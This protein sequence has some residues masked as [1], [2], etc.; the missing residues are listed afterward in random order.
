MRRAA[1]PKSQR[2]YVHVQNSPAQRLA[3]KIGESAPMPEYVEPLLATE[4]SPPRG[5]RWVHEIKYDGYRFQ[6]YFRNG[7]PQFLTRRG[8]DWTHKVRR[9]VG[10]TVHIDCHN[11]IID[12]EMVIPTENGGTDFGSL[13]TELSLGNS[14]RIAFYAFDNLYLDGY[15]LRRCGLID[16]KEVLRLLLEKAEYPIVFSDHTDDPDGP[17][18]YREACKAELEGI[19]SKR[20]DAPYSSGRSSAWIKKPCRK[21]DTFFVAGWAEKG[22]SF[23][24]LYL[25]KRS[26]RK[27]VYAGKLERG[28]SAKEEREIVA[29]LKPLVAVKQPMTATR[30]RFPKAKWVK[31]ELMVEAEFRGRTAEGLLRHPSFKGVREDLT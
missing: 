8:N 15:D 3:R 16:R 6:L 4:G 14:T 26:G 5:E 7:M 12:G 27:L 30:E 28:F 24:G 1:L 21:R 22:K 19:V 25:A 11:A 18:L 2:Q 9:V 10:A 23:D 20:K 17:G 29:M 13:K 31:P